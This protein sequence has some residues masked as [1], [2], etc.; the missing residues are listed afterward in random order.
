[1]GKDAEAVKTQ[2][3]ALKTVQEKLSKSGAYIY[4]AFIVLWIVM[5][6]LVPGFSTVS[7]TINVLKQASI[8]G[9]LAIG[10][11]FVIITGGIDLALGSIVA[12]TG[13]I[14]ALLASTREVPGAFFQP[15]EG[16]FPIV[17]VVVLSILVGVVCGLISGVVTSKGNVP[18]FIATMGMM[19]IARGAA[20]L[21]SRG[22]TVPYVTDEFIALG[23]SYVFGKIPIL[24][25]IFIAVFIVASIVLYFTKFG[26]HVYAVGGNETAAYVS[27]MNVDA[28]KIAV[29]MISGFCSG[30]A[31]LLL[32]ARISC[33]SPVVG[34]GFELDA[35]AACVIGGT[36]L[37]GGKGRLLGTL[38]GVLILGVM[39]NGLDMLNVNSYYQQMIKGVI[40]IAAVWFDSRR[41]SN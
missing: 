24:V 29:Y 5:A 20:L 34:Q 14:G 27:G 17:V 6:V 36:S 25:V 18:A 12:L 38:V 22:G 1:M 32:A 3:G 10:V 8:N 16:G 37:S 23:G 4:I 13:T 39:S 9:I 30:L 7:N 19:T 33:G 41:P 40:T 31:G 26:R 15:I 28:V 2:A 35:I 11:T 21:M